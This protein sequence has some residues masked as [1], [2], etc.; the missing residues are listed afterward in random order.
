MPPPARRRVIGG[1]LRA[2]P[3]LVCSAFSAPT[4]A[5]VGACGDPPGKH[6]LVVAPTRL[7]QDVGGISRTDRLATAA[8][9]A[10][11]KQRCRVLYIR[12]WKALAA[13]VERNLRSPLVGL[14]REASRAVDRMPDITV[15]SAQVTRPRTSGRRF[16]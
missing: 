15:E 13:D 5:Q 4:N 14:Q 11:K 8:E 10:P 9:P 1:I 3:R 6:T 16:A 2:D 12:P 7:R